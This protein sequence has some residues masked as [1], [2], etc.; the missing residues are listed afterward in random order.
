MPWRALPGEV[1]DPYHVWLSEIMLQQTTVAAVIPYFKRFTALFPDPAA[2]ASADP[3][4]VMAAWAGLGYYARARNLIRAAR[5]V[6]EADGFPRTIEGLRALPGIGPYTAHAIGAIAF[7]LPV[8]PVDGN[9]ERVAARVFAFPGVLPAARPA[10]HRVAATLGDDPAAQ[11]RPGDYAQGLFDLG[12]TICTP[13][14]PACVICPWRAC[15]AGLAQGI[16][17]ELPRKAPK[18][19]SPVRHAAVFLLRDADGRVKLE[20]RPDDGLLGGMPGL[21]CT[22]WRDAPWPEAEA[23]AAAPPGTGWRRAGSARHVFTHFTLLADIYAGSSTG[24]EGDGWR[25]P[26]EAARVLPTA[27]R[28]CLEAGLAVPDPI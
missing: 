8:I 3:D 25:D 5:M 19:A 16:A 21:P 14:G 12:A 13:R 6:A 17:A 10:L 22:A 15:C 4:T 1:S 18:A 11:A 20:R 7:G 28:R 23:I 27:M 24:A 2:L 9:I 26:E